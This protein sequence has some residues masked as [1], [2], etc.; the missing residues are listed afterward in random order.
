M[1]DPSS[2]AAVKLA[3]ALLKQY[4]FDQGELTADQLIDHWLR[5]YPARWIQMALIQALYQGR[6]KAVSVEQILRLWLRRGQPTYHFNHE[7]ERLVCHDLPRALAY[8]RHAPPASPNPIGTDQFRNPTDA[9]P[10]SSKT[11]KRKKPSNRPAAAPVVK[12]ASVNNLLSS[13]PDDLKPQLPLVSELPALPS[14]ELEAHSQRH[15]AQGARQ[16]QPTHP[17]STQ[18]AHAPQLPSAELDV[19]LPREPSG[20]LVDNVDSEY[21]FQAEHPPIHQFRPYTQDSTF[22]DKLLAIAMVWK[23]TPEAEKILPPLSDS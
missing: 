15:K 6:Y 16:E 23:Q 11:T 1:A 9:Q 19:R 7:F 4:G 8:S 21:E 3:I 13:S 12:S 18:D 20:A 2:D 22:S 10:A 17:F 5:S 14:N